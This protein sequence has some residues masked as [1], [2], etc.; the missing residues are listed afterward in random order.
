MQMEDKKKN[1][2]T[3]RKRATFKVEILY[4]QNASWQGEIIWMEEKKRLYFRSAL[5]LMRMMD[6]AFEP[7]EIRDFNTALETTNTSS[8]ENEK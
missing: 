5:E 8:F 2:S 1:E 4:Q 3:G 6:S 7:D